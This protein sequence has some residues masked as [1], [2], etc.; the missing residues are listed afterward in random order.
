MRFSCAH[1]AWT[2]FF[3]SLE[4]LLFLAKNMM[5]MRMRKVRYWP[6]Y[7]MYVTVTGSDK[8]D[9]ICNA[10]LLTYPV[11]GPIPLA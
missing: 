1:H 10:Q 5:L 3:L 11:G 9:C 6:I 7:V 8:K 2:K 4:G